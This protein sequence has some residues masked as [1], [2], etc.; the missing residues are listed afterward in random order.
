MTDSKHYQRAYEIQKKAR[1]HAEQLLERKSLELYEKNESLRRSYELLKEQSE[2]IISQEKL[3]SIGQLAA[4]LAHEINNPNAFIQS[5]LATLKEYI[6]E[7]Q[8]FVASDKEKSASDLNNLN[9]T[10]ADALALISESHD[11]TRRIQN[12]VKG[13]RYFAE[14]NVSMKSDVDLNECIEK[15]ITLVSSERIKNCDV[16]YKESALPRVQGIPILLIQALANLIRNAVEASPSGSTVTI[17][18]VCESH[19]VR[20]LIADKGCGIVAEDLEKVFEPFYSSKFSASGMGL[21]IAQSIIV[22]QKGKL[23]LHSNPNTGTRALITL[24][25]SP[26]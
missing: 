16:L 24:P 3:A 19:I 12:T 13:V 2:Q 6:E 17:E 8:D 10:L 20:I 11:G 25:I 5:N 26:N 7:V 1:Q 18:T 9:D 22:Q 4:G 15:A 23:K 14:P 21:S